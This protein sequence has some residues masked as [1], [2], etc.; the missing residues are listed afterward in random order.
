MKIISFIQSLLLLDFENWGRIL[1]TD[2]L[3]F[4]KSCISRRRIH[5][6]Y[7]VNIRLKG[8]FI[9]REVILSS[10]KSYEIIEEYPT[11]KYLPSYLICAKY[12]NQMIH[13]HIA[14]DE[15]NDNIR[16]VTAYKPTID[17]WESDFKTRRKNELS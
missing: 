5:W 17:K 1:N 13:V 9:S 8:R 3:E 4:I 16:I 12:G 2:V 10:V 11:D 6:T 14:I 7:H 15:K